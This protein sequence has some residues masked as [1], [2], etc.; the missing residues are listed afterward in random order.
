MRQ[1]PMLD[2]API[3]LVG[4]GRV[5][6][7]F[8]HYF[9][10]L[11]IPVLTW[12]RRQSTATP[13]VVFQPCRTVLVLV[14]D[15][16]IVPF[17]EAWP[18]LHGKRLVHCSGRLTTAVAEAAHPLM[19]FGPTLY[20]L[21]VYAAVPFVLDRG[22]TPFHDL[23]PGLPNPAFTIPASERPYYHA[24]CV[25]AGNFS[26]LLWGKLFDELQQRYEIPPTAAHPYLKQ[27][28]ANIMSL[29]GGALTGP[30]ARGDRDTIAAN[31]QAL[32]TDPFQAVYA[33][34]V[35]AYAQRS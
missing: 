34:F 11:G 28:M 17:I 7:H 22:G 10:Q 4:D 8:Q 25:L 26:T 5:A 1:V 31:L 15:A 2:T 23:L 9:T 29:G 19:T 13:P 30:L 18:A 32:D 33:A 16:A 21:D 20:E 6:R 27:V 12:S 14:Q 3:G 24:L 35:R